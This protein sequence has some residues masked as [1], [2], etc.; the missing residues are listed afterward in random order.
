MA[1]N[2]QSFAQ[3]MID[4]VKKYPDGGKNAFKALGEAIEN[5]LCNNT[6]AVYSWSGKM[7]SKPYTPD[8]V[9]SFNASLSPS[10]N[11]FNCSPKSYEGFISDLANF[12]KGIKIDGA[13]GFS[14][15][16]ASGVGSFTS[17]QI[18]KLDDESDIDKALIS[19]YS[20]IA[21]SIIDGWQSYF[22]ASASGVHSAYAGSASLVSVS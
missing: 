20:E 3:A 5:Y 14:F 6:D 7:T 12:L 10:G 21:Q 13:S 9:T 19:A 18:K 15:S 22:L 8:P 11:T 16:L 2:V 4:G 1:L 17:Q